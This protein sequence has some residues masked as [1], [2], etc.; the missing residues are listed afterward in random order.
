MRYAE[1]KLRSGSTTMYTCPQNV[2]R[3]SLALLSAVQG[4]TCTQ[5][6]KWKTRNQAGDR[7]ECRRARRHHL[8]SCNGHIGRHT[9]STSS[10]GCSSSKWYTRSIPRHRRSRRKKTHCILRNGQSSIPCSLPHRR[11]RRAVAT[12]RC[13]C[14]RLAAP[15]TSPCLRRNAWRYLPGE[16]PAKR[17]VLPSQRLL[18]RH[19]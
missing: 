15:R 10:R 1:V 8:C 19:Q 7:T 16:V 4:T 2:V 14:S 12:H 18:A 13:E 3:D 17:Q 11:H 9:R 6:Q 5:S